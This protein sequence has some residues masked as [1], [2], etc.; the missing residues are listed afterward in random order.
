[1]ALNNM[2]QTL[3]NK[4]I[5]SAAAAALLGFT[6]VAM[7]QT[8]P[9]PSTPGAMKMS[10]AEC[11]AAWNK[12]DSAKSGNV[13]QAQAQS[14]VTDFKAVDTNADGKLSQTEFQSGC[15]K[16]MVR[17]SATTGTGS[18]ASGAGGSTPT[19]SIKK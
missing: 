16:G 18:G 12:L 9:S 14:H 2:E 8:T 4:L 10:Q 15:D 6:S 11:Q 7:A 13:A 3:M 5:T 1:M 17:S 19:P